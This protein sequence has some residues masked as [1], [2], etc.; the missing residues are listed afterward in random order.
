MDSCSFPTI[1]VLL[2]C[3]SDGFLPGDQCNSCCS[4]S[5]MLLGCWCGRFTATFGTHSHIIPISFHYI[6]LRNACT[7]DSERNWTRFFSRLMNNDHINPEYLLPHLAPFCEYRNQIKL[8]HFADLKKLG[9]IVYNL[10]AILLQIDQSGFQK[11]Q[12]PSS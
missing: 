2:R 12:K 3:S 6:F 9:L 11:Q 10:S 5:F 8:S 4:I 1:P 7:P